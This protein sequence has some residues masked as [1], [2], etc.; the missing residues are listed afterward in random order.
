MPPLEEH[1]HPDYAATGEFI[2][3]KLRVMGRGSAPGWSTTPKHIP[4]ISQRFPATPD[5][6]RGARAFAADIL[7]DDHPLRDDATLLTS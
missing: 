2:A 3:E 5:Q 4:V 6:V 1:R 7:G